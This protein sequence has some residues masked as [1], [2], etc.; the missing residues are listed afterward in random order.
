MILPGSYANGFAPRDGRPLYPELWRGCVGAWAPC[1]GPTGLTLRDWSGFGKHG[2][3]TNMVATDWTISGGRH[4]LSTNVAASDQCITA[5]GSG[6]TISDSTLSM[7]LRFTAYSV[8]GNIPFNSG[9]G[10]SYYFQI[11]T[12]G[13]AISTDSPSFTIPSTAW[14]DGAW[15]HVS[16]A[17]D[18]AGTRVY[19]NGVQVASSASKIPGTIDATQILIGRYFAGTSWSHKGQVDDIRTY[20]RALAAKEIAFLASR[21]GIAYELA[22]RRRS[23]SAVQFNRRRRLL[24]GAGS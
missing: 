11:M 17:C 15:R 16:F 19:I 23:S 20:R 6:A 3:F 7:W 12:S 8:Y 2:A 18:T 9:T 22:P 10:T 4:A 1:L 5:V 21:R 24:I 13:T 14:T